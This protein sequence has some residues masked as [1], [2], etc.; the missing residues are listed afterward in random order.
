M[1][2][3]LY[4]HKKIKSISSLGTKEAQ[5]EDLLKKLEAK[6]IEISQIFGKEQSLIEKNESL[7]NELKKAQDQLDKI[8]NLNTT[9]KSNYE[10]KISSQNEIVKALTS[11]ND[12][13]K[14]RIQQ[15]GRI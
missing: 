9:T 13:L 12:T 2:G 15:A 3:R 10:N 8:T 14:Q 7:S 5:I 6:N 1:K 4:P 11:E